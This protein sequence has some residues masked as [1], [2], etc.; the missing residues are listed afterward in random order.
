MSRSTRPAPRTAGRGLLAE[1]HGDRPGVPAVDGDLPPDLVLGLRS[2]RDWRAEPPAPW[3]HGA[4]FE[5]CALQAAPALDRV[6][7]ERFLG[8]LPAG[9]LRAKGVL[10][11]AQ[12]PD[13]RQVY[14]RVGRRW[15]LEA[16]GGWDGQAPSSSLVLIAPRGELD[17][18]VLRRGFEALAAARTN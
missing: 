17:P 6:L 7:L 14:Q 9:L 5:S 4:A 1:R 2:R 8:A 10:W 11:L 3:D 16:D 12:D 18:G 13:H 15:R